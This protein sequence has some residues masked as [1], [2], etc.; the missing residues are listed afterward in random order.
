MTQKTEIK[1]D[2][3]GYKRDYEIEKEDG[4][5]YGAKYMRTL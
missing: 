2:Y 5:R 3:D 4:F 1:T